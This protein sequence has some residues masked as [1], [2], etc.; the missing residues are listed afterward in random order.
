MSEERAFFTPSARTDVT[1]SIKEIEKQTSA[2]VVA[3]VRSASGR[4]R[5]IDLTVGLSAAFVTLLVLLFAE[6]EFAIELMPLDVLVV[7]ALA[8][9]FSR[10]GGGARRRLVSRKRLREEAARSARSA[11]VELRIG[12][13]TERMGVL[14]FVSLFEREVV[15]VPDVGLDPEKLGDGW[16]AAVSALESSLRRRADFPAFLAALR[17]LGPALGGAIPRAD[18]KVNE[19]PDE[20][21][22]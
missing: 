6:E 20:V 5:D 19:L 9:L 3:A 2:E 8:A 14:V 16:L 17:A 4:Y 21:E 7:F 10:Y 22:G 18:G 15:V 12:R 1:L 11:F 13:T